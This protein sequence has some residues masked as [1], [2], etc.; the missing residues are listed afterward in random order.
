MQASI[1]Q[2]RVVGGVM[3]KSASPSKKSQPSSAAV[4]LS[5][6]ASSP[7]SPDLGEDLKPALRALTAVTRPQS[8][9]LVG[10]RD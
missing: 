1:G 10:A 5:P 6:V 2:V 8:E 9:N 7:S 3:E 4:V